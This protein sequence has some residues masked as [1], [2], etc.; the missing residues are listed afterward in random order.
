L[1]IA[2]GY[3]KVIATIE[4]SL[5][6]MADDDLGSFFEEIN[7][8]QEN[9][10][11][12]TDEDATVQKPDVVESVVIS[13]PAERV[14]KLE[15]SSHPVYIY[16]EPEYSAFETAATVAPSTSQPPAG[17]AYYQDSMGASEY[18]GLAQYNQWST[19]SQ[20]SAP[21]AGPQVP[22]QNKSFVR[23]GAGDVWVDDTLN[24]W[25]ENDYRIFVGDL[26]KEVTTEMLGKQFQHYKSYAKAKVSIHTFEIYTPNSVL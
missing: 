13:K 4:N 18:S 8:I 7:Q 3:Q 1:S 19:H 11:G 22:R 21:I 25:P 14:E 12:P 16:S 26:G 23:T 17:A 20:P 9:V 2:T 5:L 10:S 15:A 6:S 24:E